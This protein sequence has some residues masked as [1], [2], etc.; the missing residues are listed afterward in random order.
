MGKPSLEGLLVRVYLRLRRWR[1]Y[2]GAVAR[3][4]R[5]VLG[6]G[7]RVYVAGG[8]AEGRLTVLSDVDVVVVSPNAPR[9]GRGKLRVRLEVRDRAVEAYGLPWDYPVDIHVYSDAEFE[10]ARRRYGKL[11]EVN[12]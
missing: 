7:T 11:V 8:A 2:A 12:G 10:E 1:Q 5:D 6:P 3:A 4:A 9:D